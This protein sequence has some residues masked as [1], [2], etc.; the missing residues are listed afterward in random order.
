MASFFH[1]SKSPI[2]FLSEM[3][4]P[5]L[6]DGVSIHF[7]KDF[8]PLK[9]LIYAL[10]LVNCIFFSNLP[11]RTFRSFKASKSVQ[12]LLGTTQ[13]FLSPDLTAPRLCNNQSGSGKTCFF[14]GLIS[15]RTGGW[16]IYLLIKIKK[17]T[18]DKLES[19]KNLNMKII[20]VKAKRSFTLLKSGEGLFQKKRKKFCG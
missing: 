9:T 19:G 6:G 5:E 11:D 1:F 10:F 17:R 8:F 18:S 4:F 16:Q 20:L 13:S 2:F 12:R 15:R 3:H 7:K 14:L